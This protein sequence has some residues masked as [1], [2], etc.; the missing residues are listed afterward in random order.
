MDVNHLQLGVLS[1][2]YTHYGFKPT[3]SGLYISL[4]VID[5]LKLNDRLIL[6]PLNVVAYRWFKKEMGDTPDT[7]SVAKIASA[8]LYC[9]L[10]NIDM[11]DEIPT[12]SFTVR[13]IESIEKFVECGLTKDR[14]CLLK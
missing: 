12:V 4:K 13:Q 7:L 6:G 10:R 11:L 2:W 5:V 9:R 3:L 1:E 14:H 8:I